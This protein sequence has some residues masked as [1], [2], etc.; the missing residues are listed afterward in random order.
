ML[1]GLSQN[2][3]GKLLTLHAKCDSSLLDTLQRGGN[4]VVKTN[5]VRIAY[6]LCA[7]LTYRVKAIDVSPELLPE[8]LQFRKWERVNL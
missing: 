6:I 1:A 3:A 2:T 5:A 7:V 4:P 8:G